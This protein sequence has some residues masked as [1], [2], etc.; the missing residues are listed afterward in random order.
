MSLRS[1]MPEDVGAAT[2][3]VTAATSAPTESASWTWRPC[4][5]IALEVA[6]VS[7]RLHATGLRN[8][9]GHFL[10]RT[11]H[12]IPH[13]LRV[14]TYKWSETH[15]S[16]RHISFGSS[17]HGCKAAKKG[18]GRPAPRL[19]NSTAPGRRACWGPS[20]ATACRRSNPVAPPMPPS[21]PLP[22]RRKPDDIISPLSPP[23]PWRQVA[24]APTRR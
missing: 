5:A 8:I 19:L 1:S 17:Q 12:V 20:T 21:P 6:A 2:G 11:E 23:W 4:G 3:K 9:A 7:A 22:Q 18:Q 16:R 14:R 13:K 24:R 10:S 15:S